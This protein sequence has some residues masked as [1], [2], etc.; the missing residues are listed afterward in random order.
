MSGPPKDG[1]PM[2][3]RPRK[4]MIITVI[5]M[6]AMIARGR[7]DQRADEKEILTTY[8]GDI[9]HENNVQSEANKLESRNESLATCMIEIK[10]GRKGR[11]EATTNK[12]GKQED[13]SRNDIRQYEMYNHSMCEHGLRYPQHDPEFFFSLTVTR[14]FQR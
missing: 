8:L 14:I 12:K 13:F 9:E 5:G 2:K 6:I 4:V 10:M 11:W 7:E 1:A 3:S